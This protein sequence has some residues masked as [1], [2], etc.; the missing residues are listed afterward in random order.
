MSRGAHE[1]AF[2]FYWSLPSEKRRA[3]GI[4]EEEIRQVHRNFLADDGWSTALAAMSNGHWPEARRA[5]R[6]TVMNGSGF[7]RLEAAL[8]LGCTLVHLNPT[9]AIAKVAATPPGRRLLERNNPIARHQRPDLLVTELSNE[10]PGLTGS[11]AR[12]MTMEIQK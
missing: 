7:R 6:R 8:A 3:I 12:S 10:A 4:T 2:D 5:A 9:G 1:I 11:A